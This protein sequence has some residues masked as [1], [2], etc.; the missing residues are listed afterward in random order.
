MRT[1]STPKQVDVDPTWNIWTLLTRRVAESPDETV[2]E[3]ANPDFTAWHPISV[4][5][6]ASEAVE[7]AKGLIALGIEVGDRVAIMSR[8]RY[9]W[10]LLD[11]AIW[12]AGAVPV[13]IYETSSVEQI[14]WICSDAEVKA[15]AVETS[16]HRL[17]VDAARADL[18]HLTLMWQIDA[19]DV[20][21]LKQVGAAVPT[22]EVEARRTA[23]DLSTLAP[24]I[25]TSGTT[26]RPKGTEL[27]HGNFVLLTE[28]TQWDTSPS[29][30]RD[31]IARKGCRTVLFLPLAHV[32]AR[33]IEVI[34]VSAHTVIGHC[35][36]TTKLMP[37]LGS[38]SPTFLLAVP[39]VLEK[40]YNS[41]EQKAGGGFKLK[42][43]RR[44]AK[45]AIVYSRR[46][47]TPGGPG[48]V[49]SAQHKLFDRLVYSTLREAMGGKTRYAVSGGAALGE[50]LGHFYRGIGLI[51]LEG[52]GLTETTAPTLVNGP[53]RQKIGS[54]GVPFPATDM[55][56]A[57]D[58]ELCVR[59]VNVFEAYHNNP[60][61]TAEAF[62]PDGWFRTG[63][64]GH[65]DDDGFVWITGRK[66]ELIVTAG[67]KNVAPAILED[68]LR[69][70]PL[71]SQVV[72]VGD[73]RPFI[74]ALVTIDA[75]M[76]PGWLSNHNLPPMPLAEARVH[77][78]VRASLDRAVARA[79]QAVSRAESIRKIAILEDDFTETNGYLTPSLKV[80]RTMVIEDFAPQIESI[81]S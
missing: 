33:F 10:T 44:A 58:G 56:V 27:T 51:V 76:L 64:I 7:V 80:K 67:G 21:A 15:V 65:I 63:D 39:R 68:R 19:G 5:A 38:F 79:N 43:F 32:F 81:Y 69:G 2:I 72:V 37:A 1:V 29:N 18:P 9:E 50:R 73:N 52:Y 74:G 40:V 36:D 59:G 16:A 13:P 24:I 47:D 11:Y 8:T 28:N 14:A 41:A 54:V 49:L 70:H 6:F 30:V 53:N 61:A 62:T 20:D 26:G 22:A 75:E 71:V 42:L 17:L 60:T 34:S 45:V 12:A 25:Y 77:P 31:V 46:L 66:K 57:D 78:A 35:G 48:L 23:A 3:V 4:T 55:R